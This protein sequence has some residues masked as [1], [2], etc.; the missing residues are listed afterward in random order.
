MQTL[1]AK[2]VRRGRPPLTLLEHLRDTE[3]AAV[4]VFRL[5]RRWGTAFC[6]F[7]RLGDQGERFLRNL[8]V[9]ALF[10]DIGKA[11]AEFQAMLGA[12]G[13]STQSLRHEHISALVL[14]L[15]AVRRWLGAA[16]DLDLEVITGAVLSHHLKAEEDGQW[17]W[18]VLRGAKRIPLMLDH[19]Q[20]L[21]AFERVAEVAGLPRF[22]ERLPSVCGDVAPWLDAKADGR[23]AALEFRRELRHPE[24]GGAGPRR[25]LLL[26]VKAGLIVADSVASGLVREGHDIEAWIDDIVHGPALTA[27]ELDESII[28]PRLRQIGR[29]PIDGLHPFQRRVAARGPRTLLL[30]ACGA[31]KTLAAWCWAREQLRRHEFGRVIFL[32]P[33]R[34]TATEGFRDYVGWAPEADAALV[35]GTSRYELEAMAENPSE[36]IAGKRYS[37]EA[38]AR[39][40]ALG[41]WRKRYFSATVDQFLAFLEH[42]YASICLLPALADAVV[43]LDEVHSY[44]ESLFKHLL[45]LLESFDV[46]TLCM[47]ATLPGSRRRDLLGKGLETFPGPEDREHLADLEAKEEAPRYHIS[48]ESEV[49]DIPELV[50]A[51]LRDGRR[52]LWV[53][54]VVARCQQL[55]RTIGAGVG[56]AAICYHSRFRMKDRQR[57]HERTVSAFKQIGSPA[58][59]VTTQVCEMSLDLDADLLITE[60]A[61]CSAL[62]QRFGRANRHLARGADFRARVIVTAPAAD[63]PYE[64]DDMRVARTFVDAVAGADVTQAVLAAALL[65]HSRDEAQPKVTARFLTGG[66]Y[67]TEGSIRDESDHLVTAVLDSDLAAIHECIERRAPFDGYVL[68]APRRAALPREGCPVW[69][70][71]YLEVV[72][73]DR[74][75]MTL[76][77]LMEDKTT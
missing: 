39:L 27:E 1:L 10:H 34:G 4:N 52:V 3:A 57:A 32:Y 77:F 20:V 59:A 12:R 64:P 28:K 41:L 72:S 14:H 26:A 65:E 46:P 15:A 69:L 76:G 51:A 2:S 17:G 9:A 75:D 23:R 63:L 44:D 56:T 62:V 8:R 67:A 53:V 54:N 60:L 42:R 19:E 25:Q 21:G 35:H 73:G 22:T 33:T 31:G 66:Y 38:D 40:F 48:R 74:Y 55:A 49:A 70:P 18:G 6:R 11:N 43:I 7:F 61:P 13:E 58:L 50:R 30:A 71:R 45:V 68:S 36:A 47:T 29:D 5:D 16:A 37:D 24:R